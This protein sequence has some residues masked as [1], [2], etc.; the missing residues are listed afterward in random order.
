MKK[1]NGGKQKSEII[2]TVIY[3]RKQILINIIRKCRPW[4]AREGSIFNGTPAHVVRS[5][6]ERRA[7]RLGNVAHGTVAKKRIEGKCDS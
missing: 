5:V 1:S 6:L 3:V 2:G 7:E 4:A